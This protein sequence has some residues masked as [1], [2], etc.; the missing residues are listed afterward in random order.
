MARVLLNAEIRK[1]TPPH[2]GV[3]PCGLLD[4]KGIP[5]IGAGPHP[6]RRA[7]ASGP[8]ADEWC[9]VV[10]VGSFLQCSA[11]DL[12]RVFPRLMSRTGAVPDA[13]KSHLARCVA[14]RALRL[15]RLADGV[16]SEAR[17]GLPPL[18]SMNNAETLA[19]A[20][21]SPDDW[22]RTETA[23]PEAERAADLAALALIDAVLSELDDDA[24]RPFDPDDAGIF[25]H[26]TGIHPA[27]FWPE[28]LLSHE[29]FTAIGWL[30]HY[31]RRRPV[32]MPADVVDYFA[33]TVRREPDGAVRV[34]EPLLARFL[35]SRE[36]VED[37]W[38]ALQRRRALLDPAP[39]CVAAAHRGPA[40]P[41]WDRLRPFTINGR[42]LTQPMT[43]VQ[44]YA[45]QIVSAMDG[46]LEGDSGRVRLAAPPGV[47]AP[48]RLKA[49]A[50]ETRGRI[51]GQLW[52]QAILPAS[53]RDRSLHLCNT[54]PAI[55]RGHVVC[56]HDANVF[57]EPESY[58]RAFRNYYRLLQPWIAKRAMKVVT[59]SRDA[60][61]QL[62]RH[63][64]IKARDIAVL[65][66]G[67]E[68]ALLWDPSR[69]RLSERWT[70][71][72]PFVLLLAS[73]ARHKN[74][75][76][77]IGLAEAVDAM[78]LDL[79]VVGRQAPIFAEA[80][81]GSA[82]NLVRLG[83]VEDD[84]LAFLLSRALCLAFPSLT[85]GFGLPLVEAMAW[86]CPVV[87]SDRA[88]LPEVC[89]DAALMA[90][91]QDDRL[92]LQHFGALAGSRD[93]AD[94]LKSRGREQMKKFSWTASARG[95]LDLFES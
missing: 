55:S 50:V 36:S 80:A 1:R 8:A 26:T 44:R 20:R 52:E 30:G 82:P 23:G 27:Y 17:I 14:I 15:S 43:G 29:L 65:P 39:R 62:A 60:A 33:D 11:D 25:A 56:L 69:S 7:G 32:T 18:T 95:Y 64:D 19:L 54:A 47:A 12:F 57:I 13:L 58:S 86:G 83:A 90:N 61:L 88:S 84:D 92:W 49:I 38:Q 70:P 46:L 85:E 51:G 72:R 76:R 77:V 28:A 9:R 16:A 3:R 75:A 31:Q 41:S 5:V 79:V 59:V 34:R 22:F 74:V 68:H 67:H 4:P 94:D 35:S 37:V 71:G 21:R 24:L 87:S 78:G 63:I 66:N 48:L 89:G 45:R 6:S 53:T 2:V 40:Q 91:P 73:Q 93:L 81:A 42:F 10:A